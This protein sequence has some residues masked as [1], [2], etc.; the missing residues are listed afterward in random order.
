MERLADL[1]YSQFRAASKSGV[2]WF[3]WRN[4]PTCVL[5]NLHWIRDCPAWQRRASTCGRAL[6]PHKDKHMFVYVLE[7]CKSEALRSCQCLSTAT[8]FQPTDQSFPWSTA[9]LEKLVL[10][11]WSSISTLPSLME[12]ESLLR[13]SNGPPLNPML[14]Q[15][16]RVHTKTQ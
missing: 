10:L 9:V 5:V 2:W 14:S 8:C 11:K 16:S 3:R 6:L 1:L 12:P 7:L 13:Y 15:M 4:D